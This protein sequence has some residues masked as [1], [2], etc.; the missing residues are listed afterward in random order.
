MDNLL[1]PKP[2]KKILNTKKVEE[3]FRTGENQTGTIIFL[4]ILIVGIFGYLVFGPL[5]SAYKQNRVN[6]VNNTNEK[7]KLEEKKTKLENLAKSIDEQKDFI[8]EVEQSLPKGIEIP[9][10]LVTLE[11]AASDN[12][13]FITNFTPKEASS[14]DRTVVS[15]EAGVNAGAVG[16]KPS[17]P[18]TWKTQE[19]VFDITGNYSAVYN[20][21]KEL[22]DNIRPF[23]IKV[24]SVNGSGDVR[25]GQPLLRFSVTA[26]I[27]Y[28][29]GVGGSKE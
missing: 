11:K 24:I 1:P 3:F 6:I 10:I 2:K 13:L 27:F 17:A 18:N 8:E 22:E 29:E 19:I 9:E 12:S 15:G 16:V 5:Y 26:N 25:I 23:H 21:V 20:F 14:A 4:V 7:A 28:Q